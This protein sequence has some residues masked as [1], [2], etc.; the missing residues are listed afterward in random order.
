MGSRLLLSAQNLVC[1]VTV[2]VVIN[3]AVVVLASH[4]LVV[5]LHE[6]VFP[7]LFTDPVL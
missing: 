7:L 5:A 1:R 6:H 2:S 4:E 3:E